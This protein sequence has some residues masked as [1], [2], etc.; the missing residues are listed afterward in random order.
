MLRPRSHLS[1]CCIE[2]QTAEFDFE[3]GLLTSTT[4]PRTDEAPDT[5]IVEYTYDCKAYSY[6]FGIPINYKLVEK[7]ISKSEILAINSSPTA[8][9]VRKD[10]T[11]HISKLVIEFD[12]V[13]TFHLGRKIPFLD[14]KFSIFCEGKPLHYRSSTWNSNSFG[15]LTL[16]F[17]I[18]RVEEF[19][20][21]GKRFFTIDIIMPET[22][23]FI[24]ERHAKVFE[25][26]KLD[27]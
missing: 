17:D 7:A 21:E 12:P 11:S 9:G 27:G 23:F 8:V 15:V 19:P 3:T 14:W 2:S 4:L 22:E 1:F 18:S 24:Q 20:N 16:E 6:A 13:D 26:F 5:K 25:I 10:P